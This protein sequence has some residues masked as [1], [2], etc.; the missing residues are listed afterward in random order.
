MRKQ[1]RRSLN[2]KTCARVQSVKPPNFKISKLPLFVGGHHQY[3][4][5]MTSMN[6]FQLLEESDMRQF[7]LNIIRDLFPHGIP[8]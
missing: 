5:L 8:R 4:L 2:S 3:L 7:R 1:N 6:E